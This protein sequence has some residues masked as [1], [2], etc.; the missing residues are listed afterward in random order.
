MFLILLIVISMAVYGVWSFA[1]SFKKAAFRSA[2]PRGRKVRVYSSENDNTPIYLQDL[3]NNSFYQLHCNDDFFNSFDQKDYFEPYVLQDNE[4][5]KEKA[6]KKYNEY[7]ESQ[8]I[9]ISKLTPKIKIQT[10]E[11]YEH[12][13][14]KDFIGIGKAVV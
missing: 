7:F 3:E 4:R 8:L 13:I 10:L 6:E 2:A 5:I 14:S 11:G 9:P 12:L 1:R